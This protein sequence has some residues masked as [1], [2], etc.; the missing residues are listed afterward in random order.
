[1]LSIQAFKGIDK[2][3]KATW[4]DKQGKPAI[5]HCIPRVV[6]WRFVFGD[7]N[8]DPEPQAFP[9]SM[10][11]RENFAG[12]RVLKCCV[13]SNHFHVLLEVQDEEIN[14]PDFGRVCAERLLARRTAG[15]CEL[16][17]CLLSQG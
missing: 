16:A 8:P 4:A 17:A 10:R 13:M 2:K 14:S 6:D 9:M 3:Q 5:Y 15:L 7:P 11:M 1:M 12:C